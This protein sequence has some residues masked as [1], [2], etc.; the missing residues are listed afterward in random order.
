[1]KLISF[2]LLLAFVSYSYTKVTNKIFMFPA[3]GKIEYDPSIPS[4][5]VIDVS[6]YFI[7]DNIYL[8]FKS[9]DNFIKG[10]FLDIEY[11]DTLPDFDFEPIRTIKSNSEKEPDLDKKKNFRNKVTFVIPVENRKYLVIKNLQSDGNIIEIE[12][13]YFLPLA[14]K[15]KIG[16]VIQIFLLAILFGLITLTKIRDEILINLKASKLKEKK[17]KKKK[18]KKEK[19][20]KI[21]NENMNIELEMQN[22]I[23]KPMRSSKIPQSINE[24]DST[25]EEFGKEFDTELNIIN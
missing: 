7:S 2:L 24:N 4:L 5:S 23:E 21:K 15:I 13:G 3:Y 17:K 12:N 8:T 11:T 6:K 19:K 10:D 1:M 16:V 25:E 20:N 22:I 9:N 18:Q 14:T